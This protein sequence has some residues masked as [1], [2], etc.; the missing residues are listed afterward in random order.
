[1]R[2]ALGATGERIVRQVVGAGIVVTGAGVVI[3]VGIALI[4]GRYVQPLLFD[5]SAYDPAVVVAVA[6]AVLGIGAVA[7]WRP[8]RRAASVDPMVALRSE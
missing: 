5:V 6:V 2:I 4:A 8:A 3:G 1:V 7:A